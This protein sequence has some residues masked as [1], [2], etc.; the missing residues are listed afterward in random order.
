MFKVSTGVVR[1]IA[2]L[3]AAGVGVFAQAQDDLEGLVKGFVE[4]E[5]GD[6]GWSYEVSIHS[7]RAQMPPCDRAEPYI[8]SQG[9]FKPGLNIVGVKCGA[10][11]RY[12]RVT[13]DAT[14]PYLA[15]SHDIAPGEVISKGM[16]SEVTGDLADL[17][18]DYAGHHDEV[19]GLR[20]KTRLRAGEAIRTGFLAAPLLVQRG[21]AIDVKVVGQGFSISRKAK[22]LDSGSKGDSVRL[23]Y[24]RGKRLTAVVVD[25]G[26]VEIRP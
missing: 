1:L 13:I 2:F 19:L 18:H 15:P 21:E 10:S 16:L 14:G 8:H 7:P 17:P 12:F 4:S 11:S 9:R 25:H 22:A 5:L 23:S 3:T 26:I 20:A 6:Y 24:G